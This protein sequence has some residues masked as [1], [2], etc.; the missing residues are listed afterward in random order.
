MRVN[1][2][3]GRPSRPSPPSGPPAYVMWTLQD[4][5]RHFGILYEELYKKRGKKQPVL[6]CIGYKISDEG[7]DF[8]R[9]MAKEFRGQY[10]RVGK[11]DD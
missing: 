11:L 6:N 10:R 5:K 4:F 9:A 8:L 7:S 1:P 3:K 2:P